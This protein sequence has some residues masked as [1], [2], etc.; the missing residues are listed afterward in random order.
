MDLISCVINLRAK[1]TI[2]SFDFSGHKVHAWFLDQIH[3][4]NPEWSAQLHLENETRP[5]TVSPLMDGESIART[6]TAGERYWFR[7]TGL[8]ST[9]SQTIAALAPGWQGKTI[10]IHPAAF[11]VETCPSD[12]NHHP[13]AGEA[14]YETLQ[15]IGKNSQNNKRLPLTFVTPT[16]FSS[17][18][19][20]YVLPVPKLIYWNV[21]SRLTAMY[22]RYIDFDLTKFVERWTNVS[23]CEGETQREVYKNDGHTVDVSGFVGGELICFKKYN[24]KSNVTSK[25]WEQGLAH[26]RMLGALAFY[27][28]VGRYTARGFGMVKPDNS[29]K[30]RY[31]E[32]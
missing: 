14:C 13:W 19:Y 21:W 6:I 18:G 29:I 27:F 8:T 12:P 16:V 1:S 30:S 28:G 3:N 31:G 25:Q 4:L 32:R 7:I 5:F 11:Q 24:K 22:P 26:L 23:R 10:D 15:Q 20:D 2:L 17:D 9:W